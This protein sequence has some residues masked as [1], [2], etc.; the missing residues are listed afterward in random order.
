[1]CGC[2]CSNIDYECYKYSHNRQD[3]NDTYSFDK[4]DGEELIET[5]YYD[6]RNDVIFS[7]NDEG[8]YFTINFIKTRKTCRDNFSKTHATLVAKSGKVLMYC[9]YNLKKK[10]K[11]AYHQNIRNKV[12]EEV[13]KELSVDEPL[14][15]I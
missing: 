2:C 13:R 4:L 5:Y 6:F 3:E 7:K 12:R 1:M 14:L 15:S 8:K 9:H 11:E 10:L